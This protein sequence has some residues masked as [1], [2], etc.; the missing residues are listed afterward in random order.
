MLQ[1]DYSD[2]RLLFFVQLPITSYDFKA[3]LLLKNLSFIFT[4]MYTSA[5]ICY[6]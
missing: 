3:E 6:N 5:E 1:S 4:F 2:D